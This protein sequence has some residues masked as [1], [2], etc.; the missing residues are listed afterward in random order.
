MREGIDVSKY[1]GAIS[2]PAVASAGIQFAWPRVGYRGYGASGRITM[3]PKFREYMTG[4]EAAGIETDTL[5][6]LS[7]AIT[8]AEG[9]EEARWCVSQ[10][11]Q[12]PQVKRI[13]IDSEFANSTHTG[14][15]DALTRDQRTEVTI[16][17]CEAV[18]D[19][20]YKA[21]VYASL[22][23]FQAHLILDRLPYHIWTARYGSK[24]GMDCCAWQ[25]SSNGS[26]AGIRGRVDMDYE[27]DGCVLEDGDAPE[28]ELGS[29]TLRAKSLWHSASRG[30][31]VQNLQSALSRIGIYCAA[32]G[33]FGPATKAA[34]QQY[35]TS[36][37][38]TPDGIVGPATKSA[39]YADWRKLVAA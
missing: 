11:A 13:A 2:W 26:V 29:E 35:Q 3:D 31:Y 33:I 38:L 18:K 16:A 28:L 30:V 19:A 27:Y 6:F 15:A 37:R 34:V 23:W 22:C 20:G 14:R 1:Q 39:L 9:T 17:F 12:Y 10:A 25:Y 5:Y 7:Q 36:R 4:A 32:D 24:P 21:A 8:S